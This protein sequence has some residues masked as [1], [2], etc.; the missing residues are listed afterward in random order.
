MKKRLFLSM[1]AM[2][3]WQGFGCHRC[4]KGDEE[5]AREHLR[6]QCDAFEK[7]FL[8]PTME[9]K[10]LKLVTVSLP[11][12]TRF[13]KSALVILKKGSLHFEVTFNDWNRQP[14]MADVQK[15][16]EHHVRWICPFD[17]PARCKALHLAIEPD[18]PVARIAELLAMLSKAGFKKISFIFDPKKKPEFPRPLDQAL[19]DRL[20]RS[21]TK[22]PIENKGVYLFK[23]IEKAVRSTGCLAVARVIGKLGMLEYKSRCRLMEKELPQ[24]LVKCRCAISVSWMLT[25]L[26]WYFRA[27]GFFT[28]WVVN[29][30]PK[31]APWKVAKDET[32]KEIADRII[33][34][35]PS[36]FW[37]A[38]H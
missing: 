9:W 10:D 18:V 33:E 25:H 38:V 31:E 37:L 23:R 34:Q 4:K 21:L 8:Y 28:E 17:A 24:A 32:W 2:F 13:D 35:K 27:F 1:C 22:V 26:D 20:K 12:K 16:L 36:F 3:I 6:R 5:R 7:T 15:I 19:F 14:Q 30:S 11:L 29:L